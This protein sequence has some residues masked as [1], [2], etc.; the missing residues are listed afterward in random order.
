VR[1]TVHAKE[2]LVGR[3]T[4]LEEHGIAVSH[5]PPGGDKTAAYVAVNGTFAGVITLTDT[6]RQEATA[7]IKQLERLGIKN[8]SMITGDGYQAAHH[9][10]QQ[11]GISDVTAEA[12]PADKLK[13]IEQAQQPVAFVGDGVN[14]APVLTASSVGI[15][16]TTAT[17]SYATGPGASAR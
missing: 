15:V 6:L 8:F 4:L 12:L 3:Q 9:I 13:A 14:D 2:A 16:T 17:V 5:K 1:G 10:A 7:T 11:A